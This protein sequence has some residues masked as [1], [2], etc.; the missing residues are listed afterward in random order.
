MIVYVYIVSFLDDD[1]DWIIESAHASDKLANLRIGKLM[2]ENNDYC[3][4]NYDIEELVL[5]T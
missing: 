5:N 3:K 4:G 1:G 2:E